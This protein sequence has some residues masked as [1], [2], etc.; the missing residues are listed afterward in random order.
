MRDLCAFAMISARFAFRAVLICASA[1]FV[2]STRGNAQ[3][4]EFFETKIR[5]IFVEHCYKCHSVQAEKL[6]GGLL[7]DTREGLLKG[8]D[9]G[10]A[11]APGNPEKSLL[12][13]AVR[14]TD[15]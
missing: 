5:P 9:S 6:K 15:K 4:F 2:T 11:I 3:D 8:G 1:V 12:I 13:K 14:Y 10:P 7:L